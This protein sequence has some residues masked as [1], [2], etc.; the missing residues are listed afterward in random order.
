[1]KQI[2]M[3]T[4]SPTPVMMGAAGTFETGKPRDIDDDLAEKLLV[5]S[6]PNFVDVT[7]IDKAGAPDKPTVTAK[8]AKADKGGDN[9]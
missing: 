5:R 3:T 7:T 4:E 9:E 6:F 2:V 1:M 8:A